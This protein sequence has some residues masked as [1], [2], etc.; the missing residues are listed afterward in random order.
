MPW[1][2]AISNFQQKNVYTIEFECRNIYQIPHHL[3][4]DVYIP[5]PFIEATVQ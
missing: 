2:I 4:M 3:A 5:T 1:A